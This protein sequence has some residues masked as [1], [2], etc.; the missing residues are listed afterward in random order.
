MKRQKEPFLYFSEL[1]AAETD[2]EFNDVRKRVSE[3]VKTNY[4]N[5]FLYHSDFYWGLCRLM[6]LQE[7]TSLCVQ[8]MQSGVAKRAG[9]FVPDILTPL[10][11][12]HEGKD[13]DA[14]V[15]S[16][17][18]SR[19]S[20]GYAYFGLGMKALSEGRRERAKKC[21]L[22]CVDEGFYSFY[23]IQWSYVILAK[24]DQDPRWPHW[25]ESR[26]L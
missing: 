26:D 2:Y 20:L 19:R 9:T 18:G 23:I 12:V 6:N 21:F 7:E 10:I 3:T 14:L 16:S 24:L 8:L 15:E 22:H 11:D 4:A 5:D 13:A 1:C 17:Q 25:I